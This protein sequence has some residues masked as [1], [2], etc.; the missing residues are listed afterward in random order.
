M[1]ILE[2]PKKHQKQEK[3]KIHAS[4]LTQNGDP[5]VIMS[6]CAQDVKNPF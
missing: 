2:N 1:R 3:F 6:Q 5:T 4:F